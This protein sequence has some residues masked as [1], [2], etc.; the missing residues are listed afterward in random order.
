MYYTIEIDKQMKAYYIIIVTNTSSLFYLFSIQH[1]YSLK[2]QLNY[3]HT[4]IIMTM[5]IN[6]IN[7][8]STI[9]IHLFMSD[10]IHFIV[11]YYIN[12]KITYELKV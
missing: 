4:F 1:K 11:Y 8:I 6:Y 2:R 9:L 3:Q 12:T 5:F 10:T 7:D